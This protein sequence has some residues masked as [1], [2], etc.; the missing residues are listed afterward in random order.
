MLKYIGKRLL[1]LIPILLGVTIL[2]F[3]IRAITPGD[4]VDHLVSEDASEEVREELREDLG[5]NKPLVVQFLLYVKGIVTGDLGTSYVTKEPVLK[6]LL[7]RLPTT[8]IVCFGAVFLGLI[9]GVPL[10][11]ASAQKPYSWMDSVILVLSMIARSIP[12]FCLAFVLIT[13]FAVELHWLPAVG[14][15]SWKSYVLP[16]ATIGLSS[17]ANYT[18][19]TRSSMLEIVRQDYVRTARAK[20]QTEGKI[21]FG[22]ELRN[23]SI[24]IVASIGNQVGR[25]LGGALII[26]TVFGVPGI[27]KYIG[28]AVGAR[29][30]PAIQGGVLFLA[31]IFAIVNLLVDL[32][33]VVINPRL[34]TSVISGK[35]RKKK[36]ATEKNPAACA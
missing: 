19:I 17:M 22:H 35:K 20:G 21:V 31:F 6:E 28:D 1:M 5:L 12:G 23:A 16:M 13:I 33:F 24:P 36:K 27:G 25:Q 10:G 29:N 15:S 8:L 9:L 14:I 3:C 26:E 11:I 18:R 32:S 7:G 34:K 2:V 4:P 30:F